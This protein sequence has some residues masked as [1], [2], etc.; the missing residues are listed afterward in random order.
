LNDAS[1]NILTVIY[2]TCLLI[3][4]QFFHSISQQQLE[5]VFYKKTRPC[6]KRIYYST[7]ILN[8]SEKVKQKSTKTEKN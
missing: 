5:I 8:K 6:E 1:I 3:Q 7:L 4:L 2:L